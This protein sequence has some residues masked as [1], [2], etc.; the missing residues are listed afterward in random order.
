MKPYNL[1]I[2][3]WGAL[4]C[5]AVALAACDGAEA[6]REAGRS[7]ELPGADLAPVNCDGTNQ[8]YIDSNG[9]YMVCVYPDP[10]PVPTCE[11][12]PGGCFPDPE[13]P[14]PTEPPDPGPGG[15]DPPPPDP[16]GE[17]NP[18]TLTCTNATDCEGTADCRGRTAADNGTSYPA[19][20]VE[21]GLAQNMCQLRCQH[22]EGATSNGVHHARIT[23]MT[24]QSTGFTGYA[25]EGSCDCNGPRDV[26]YYARMWCQ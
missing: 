4:L 26:G 6:G 8:E 22:F 18:S 7:V 20:N 16:G 15:G 17:R 19:S 3:A 10:D 12:L 11:L 5:S 1:F 24:N 23:Y 25:L 21:I 2:A 13:P 9:N 14:D